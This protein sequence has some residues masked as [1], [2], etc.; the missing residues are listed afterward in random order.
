MA[1]NVDDDTDGALPSRW[2]LEAGRDVHVRQDDVHD[3]FHHL[4]DPI[5]SAPNVPVRDDRQRWGFKP[6]ISLRSANRRAR[7]ASQGFR[8]DVPAMAGSVIRRASAS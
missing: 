6:V 3:P 8:D 7:S 5:H 2:Q 4:A 1:T